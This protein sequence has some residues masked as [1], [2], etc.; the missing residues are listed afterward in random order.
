MSGLAGYPSS[1][2]STKCCPVG[3]GLRF[4][5]RRLGPARRDVGGHGWNGAGG[6]PDS[7]EPL[8]SAVIVLFARLDWMISQ[9][10]SAR[11]IRRKPAEGQQ[12]SRR[13]VSL[14]PSVSTRW[15]AEPMVVSSACSCRAAS[16]SIFPIIWADLLVTASR[17]H[18]RSS[19]SGVRLTKPA[20]ARQLG[21]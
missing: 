15:A 10:S 8:A 3:G 1:Q 11:L 17:T 6:G 20:R 5:E 2:P 9:R 12:A 14:R 21:C 4:A 19:G 13:A 16:G 18:R 7:R